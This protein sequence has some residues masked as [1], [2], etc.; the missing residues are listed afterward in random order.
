MGDLYPPSEKRLA[1]LRQSDVFPRSRI[2]ESTFALAGAVAGSWLCGPSLLEK[3]K[4]ISGSAFDLSKDTK[5]FDF[6]I[7]RSLIL[8]V[9]FILFVGAVARLLVIKAESRILIRSPTIDVGRIFRIGANIGDFFKD[10][11]RGILVSAAVM[12]FGLFVLVAIFPHMLEQLID[13]KQW[14]FVH[15]LTGLVVMALFGT[16]ELF[17]SVVTFG[18]RYGMTRDELIAEQQELRSE[19]KSEI[20]KRFNDGD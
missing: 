14:T 7:I 11:R 17:R 15:L 1:E 19:F 6:Q 18:N 9:L 3:I 2:L 13:W 4:Q 5:N 8:S 16:L 12:S 10:A 20:Q